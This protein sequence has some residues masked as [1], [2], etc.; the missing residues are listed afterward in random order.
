MACYLNITYAVFSRLM[1]SQRLR[2]F[3]FFFQVHFQIL[4]GFPP[5]LPHP[6]AA[7][8]TCGQSCCVL[9]VI[10]QSRT[11]GSALSHSHVGHI[12][13]P[14]QVPDA[15]CPAATRPTPEAYKQ[16]W[17][18]LSFLVGNP[19]TTTR[20]LIV[21]LSPRDTQCCKGFGEARQCW[22]SAQTKEKWPH[23]TIH[24]VSKHLFA[25][26]VSSFSHSSLL[27][28]LSNNS[29]LDSGTSHLSKTEMYTAANINTAKTQGEGWGREDWND[30]LLT[31]NIT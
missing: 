3:F 20:L 10:S 2:L 23:L 5:C 19:W 7:V 29:S 25:I 26:I 18:L 22:S 8:C 24:T 27:V 31:C 11:Q 9:D 1:F 28:I 30:N 6:T 21:F 15:A 4:L 14:E 17:L 12:V 13:H 16:W